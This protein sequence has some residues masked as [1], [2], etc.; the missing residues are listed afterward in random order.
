MISVDDIKDLIPEYSLTD[1]NW[2]RLIA[3]EAAYMLRWAPAHP[4]DAE[5]DLVLVDLIKLRLAYMGSGST[6]VG[7]GLGAW[8][9]RRA[10]IVSQ[11][12]TTFA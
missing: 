1:S 2:Q 8:Q 7:N 6:E 12:A 3:G 9:D 10:E 5:H 11:I 4:D